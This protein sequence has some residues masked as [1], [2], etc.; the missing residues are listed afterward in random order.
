MASMWLWLMMVVI[1]MINHDVIED[2]HG[3]IL[4]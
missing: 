4:F 3:S 2:G 1:M